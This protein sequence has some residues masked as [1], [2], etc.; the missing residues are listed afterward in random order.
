MAVKTPFEKPPT[1]KY[2]IPVNDGRK[3]GSGDI[4]E[5]ITVEIITVTGW[6][7]Q[8]TSLLRRFLKHKFGVTRKQANE[9]LR[10]MGFDDLFQCVG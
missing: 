2:A 6:S 10:A 1:Y 9:V 4:T 8:R 3:E 7:R 5:S